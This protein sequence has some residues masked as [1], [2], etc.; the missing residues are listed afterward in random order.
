VLWDSQGCANHN[1]QNQGFH[2]FPH[3]CHPWIWSSHRC[4]QLLTPIINRQYN[5]YKCMKMVTK[6]G[7]GV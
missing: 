4:W 5:L 1:K 7:L 2:R 6:I 3:L